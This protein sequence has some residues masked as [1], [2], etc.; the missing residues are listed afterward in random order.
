MGSHFVC[1]GLNLGSKVVVVVVVKWVAT[2]S[3]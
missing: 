1:R 2:M 3:L